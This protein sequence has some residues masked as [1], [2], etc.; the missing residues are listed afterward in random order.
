MFNLCLLS[1]AYIFAHFDPEEARWISTTI[2]SNPPPGL[3]CNIIISA[4]WWPIS[5][6]AAQ[7]QKGTH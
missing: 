4:L 1:G 3:I 5:P 6:D 2:G 7:E